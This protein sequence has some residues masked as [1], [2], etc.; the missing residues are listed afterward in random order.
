M[1]HK[2]RYTVLILGFLV[3]VSIFTIVMTMYKK[4]KFGKGDDFTKGGDNSVKIGNIE[5]CE[6]KE[7]IYKE[8]KGKP[9]LINEKDLLQDLEVSS[10]NNASSDDSFNLS[11]EEIK[12]LD[13]E[14]LAKNLKIEDQITRDNL[15]EELN[16]AKP[17][18]RDAIV[19]EY[20]QNNEKSSS[21]SWAKKG[22]KAG[23]RML[24]NIYNV[25]K[26]IINGASS[27][28]MWVHRKVNELL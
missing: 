15:F 25:L 16:K 17:E 14:K 22:F 18:E 12:K 4:N 24:I 28:N 3:G 6:I 9:D 2:T 27:L 26:K 5:E 13:F 11:P 7:D 1:N 23:K 8:K 19:E 20:E 10:N 21:D